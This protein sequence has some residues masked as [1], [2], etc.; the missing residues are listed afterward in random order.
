MPA[1][2]PAAVSLLVASDYFDWILM[3]FPAWVF[4]VSGY[5]LIEGS[6]P[7]RAAR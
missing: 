6:P 3:V 5:L 7:G 4:V 2:D 1:I